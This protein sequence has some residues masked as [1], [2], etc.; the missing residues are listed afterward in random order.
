MQNRPDVSV[1]GFVVEDWST[2]APGTPRAGS[3][4]VDD[5]VGGGAAVRAPDPQPANRKTSPRRAPD[6]PPP[7]LRQVRTAPSPVVTTP[8]GR[9]SVEEASNRWS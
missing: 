4:D 5:V 8:G 3:S 9:G 1:T 6:A 2:T 7:D